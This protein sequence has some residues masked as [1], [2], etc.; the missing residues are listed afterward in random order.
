MNPSFVSNYSIKPYIDNDNNQRGLVWFVISKKLY[1]V[2]LTINIKARKIGSIEYI[3]LYKG[4]INFCEISKSFFG[5]PLKEL[6]GSV[7]T[8][9][10]NITFSCPIE[11]SLQYVDF[12]VS[13]LKLPSF[14]PVFDNEFIF[15]AVGRTKLSSKK[16]VKLYN[17]TVSGMT[18]LSKS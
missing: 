10:G 15:E 14:I 9:N 4:N 7:L 8:K 6:I 1:N 11:A 16:I 3:D 17:F 5:K 18:C 2:L 13:D 12:P